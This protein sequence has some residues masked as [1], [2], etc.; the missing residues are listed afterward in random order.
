MRQIINAT[1]ALEL[2]AGHIL[3]ATAPNEHDVVFLKIVTDSRNI[4]DHL[5]AGWEPH[6]NAFSIS[7]VW[8]TRLLD[9]DLQDDSLRHRLSIERLSRWSNFEMRSR[10][11]HLIYCCH[12]ASR[13]RRQSCERNNKIEIWIFWEHDKRTITVSLTDHYSIILQHVETMIEY[14]SFSS[15]KE[16]FSSSFCASFS[17]N[18]WSQSD[19]YKG[20]YNGSQ[21][22]ILTTGSFYAWRML[23]FVRSTIPFVSSSSTMNLRDWFVVGVFELSHML[24]LQI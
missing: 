11:V 3:K 10:T 20:R 6:E 8:L 12:V 13:Y 9:E 7:G 23:H 5:L 15:W 17:R 18:N 19:G 24:F 14:D 21:L 16:S 1:N 22:H 2:N 4:S